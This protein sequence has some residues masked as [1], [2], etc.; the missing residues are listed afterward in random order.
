MKTTFFILIFTFFLGFVKGNS[1]L[2]TSLSKIETTH[3]IAIFWSVDD[4]ESLVLIQKLKELS[5]DYKYIRTKF[6]FINT[7]GVEKSTQVI[8]FQR[9]YKLDEDSRFI[10][11]HDYDKKFSKLWGVDKTT[12]ILI[13]KSDKSYIID[14]NLILNFEKI[15]LKLNKI[16]EE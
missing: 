2:D 1:T 13:D 8:N 16:T 12:L 4:L 14:E 6:N 7:D 3:G 10:L 9:L 11:L 5:T 15:K